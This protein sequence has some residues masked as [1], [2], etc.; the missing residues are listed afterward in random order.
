[1]PRYSIYL[2]KVVLYII[3]ASRNEGKKYFRAD[4]APNAGWGYCDKHCFTNSL[5]E[6]AL[7]V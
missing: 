5:F 2:K 7:Q 3:K 6:G 1:M 4:V